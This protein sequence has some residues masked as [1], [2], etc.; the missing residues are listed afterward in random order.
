MNMDG[1]EIVHW[2]QMNITKLN[3]LANSNARFNGKTCS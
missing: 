3:V 1:M 2:H